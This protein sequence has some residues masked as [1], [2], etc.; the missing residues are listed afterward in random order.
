MHQSKA[1]TRDSAD[2]NSKSCHKVL[3]N[4]TSPMVPAKTSR[5]AAGP[6]IEFRS[7]KKF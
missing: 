6:K 5:L 3:A 4:L 7:K 1:R 2:A